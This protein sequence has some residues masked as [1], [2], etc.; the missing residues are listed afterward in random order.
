MRERR[1]IRGELRVDHQTE[2][3]EAPS[4]ISAHAALWDV[5]TTIWPGHDEVIRSGAFRESIAGDTEDAVGLFNHDPMA[6]LGRHS[7]GT[8]RLSEDDVGLR[9]E[10]DAPDTQAGRDLVTSIGRGD[11][12]GSSFQFEAIEAPVATDADGVEVREV[13]TARLYDVSPVVFPAYPTDDVAVRA[14]VG[15]ESSRLAHVSRATR[16]HVTELIRGLLDAGLTP[17]DLRAS[18]SSALDRS[19]GDPSAIA[20]DLDERYR[21][22]E[23][24]SK[25]QL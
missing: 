23:L 5:Q 9:Y 24:A 21:R 18:I 15:F 20:N 7:A 17:E 22:L 25:Q 10:I 12:V 19:E 13:R 16:S 1:T 6:L 11:V 14:L 8:L 2:G 3:G 4:I